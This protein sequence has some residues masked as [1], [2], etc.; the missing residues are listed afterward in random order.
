MNCKAFLAPIVALSLIV[1]CG[2]PEG[3]SSSGSGEPTGAAPAGTPE[4]RKLI[5]YH[6]GSLSVPFKKV[7]DVFEKAHPG[8]D[9]QRHA[10][11]S[12]M[13]IRQVTELKKPADVIASADYRLI[14]R[15]MIE[16]KP[17]WAEWD[18]M[19]ARNAICLALKPGLKGVTKDNWAKKVMEPGFRLGMSNPNHDPC[20]YRSIMMLYLAQERLGV[21]GMFDDLVLKN[22]TITIDR[23]GGGAVISVPTT[24]RFK[25]Q[26]VVRPKETDLIPLLQTGAITGL[27]IYRSVATQHKMNFVSL[28]DKVNL[29]DPKEAEAYGTVRVMLNAGSP[30]VVPVRCSAIVYGV[31]IPT[32]V[33]SPKLAKAFIQLLTGPEGQRIL[34]ECGQP[35]LVPPPFSSVSAKVKL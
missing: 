22:S 15:M 14:D 12:A 9:V 33:R 34:S 20:G 28:P 3:A 26:L 8:V 27:V 21:K 10:Y 11:G 17:K 31:T 2:K 5:I 35:P 4:S 18:L 16:V 7:E 25:G 24:V 13:A 29:S 6:A 32:S 23:E 1:G 30:K 19:F